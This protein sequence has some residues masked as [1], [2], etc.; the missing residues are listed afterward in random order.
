MT[1]L[2]T[3]PSENQLKTL[4]GR[5]AADAKVPKQNRPE[6]CDRI[7]NTVLAI[8]LRDR[9]ST[10]TI[11]G[12]MLIEA[13]DAARELNKFYSRMNQTDRDW[14][15]H[16]KSVQGSVFASGEIN[17]L[18][19]TI[20]NISMLLDEALG[21]PPAVKPV[22]A[23]GRSHMARDRFFRELVFALLFAAAETGGHFTLN[24]NS[25]GG[26]TLAL[27]LSRLGTH[28]PKGLVASPPPLQTI[29]RLKLDFDRL[30]RF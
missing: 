25:P 5:L 9:R 27:A 21:R 29:R 11:P 23:F 2:A 26:G 28:L 3:Y 30:H 19:T 24:R 22:K 17:D 7:V 1:Q 15:E 18:G 4:A 13:A 14:V 16:I 20:S 12:G 10:V 6:F 8:R